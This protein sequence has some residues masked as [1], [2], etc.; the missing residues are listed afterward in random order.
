MMKKKLLA[1]TVALTILTCTG[2]SKSAV[3][4]SPNAAEAE[5]TTQETSADTTVTAEPSPESVDV[6]KNLFNVTITIPSSYAGEITQDELDKEVSEKGYKSATL[7]DDGSV[8][9]KMTKSQHEQ[10]MG[11]LK[12]NINDSLAQMIGTE[13]YPN[14]KDIEVNDDY[15]L[16]TVTTSSES[17]NM[18][19]A[20]SVMTLYMYGGLYNLYNG[21]T[22]DNIHVDFVNSDTG[23]VFSSSDSKDM[24]DEDGTE[25]VENTDSSQNTEISEIETQQ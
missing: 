2:C 1:T 18:T 10:M 14:F 12:Q 6:E 7:N 17:L 3:D 23:E 9:Y 11:E 21:S 8:T 22:I 13:D 5:K 20:F 16:F 24:N 25:P 15:T 19:E 4:T